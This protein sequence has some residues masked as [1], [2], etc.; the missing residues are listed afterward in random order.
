MEKKRPVKKGDKVKL[1]VRS[2]GK[3][4]DFMFMKDKFR[5]FL[6]NTDNRTISL[7]TMLHIKVVKLFEKLGYVEL[8]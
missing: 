1:A 4:G 5:L 3:N 7:N 8:V 6:K 2:I